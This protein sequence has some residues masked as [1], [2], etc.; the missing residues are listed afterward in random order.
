MDSTSNNFYLTE[1]QLEVGEVSNPVFEHRSFNEE[2]ILCQRYYHD[3]PPAG[4][5]QYLWAFPIAGASQTFRRLSY[6]FPTTM[7]DTPALV[8]GV[9]GVAGGTLQSGKP[10]IESGYNGGTVVNCDLQSASDSAYCWFQ[11]GAFDAEL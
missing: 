9:A 11:S 7:R 4:G 3:G 8:N 2:L 10:T 1:V 5:G 6:V